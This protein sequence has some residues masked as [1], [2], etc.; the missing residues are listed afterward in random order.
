VTFLRDH[1]AGIGAAATV[2]GGVL[3]VLLSVISAGVY[4][5]VG[6]TPAQVGL[7]YGPM[8]IAAAALLLWLAAVTA[9]YVALALGA[10]WLAARLGR[11][12]WVLVLLFALLA[13]GALLADD[14]ATAGSTAS[15]AVALLVSRRRQNRYAASAVVA[16]AFGVIVGFGV[17]FWW[18]QRAEDDILAGRSSSGPWAGPWGAE[19]VSIRAEDSSELPTDRCLLY[20]GEAD[21]LTVLYDPSRE[22]WRVPTN[23]LLIEV[24]PD[25]FNTDDCDQ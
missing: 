6:V 17:I 14:P 10:T 21:G 12:W 19:V 15:V 5:S 22:T 23:A 1:V 11:R 9:V 16:V 18:A 7:G 4:E 25:A 8:L 2:V 13:G 24:H 3:Y 20:L